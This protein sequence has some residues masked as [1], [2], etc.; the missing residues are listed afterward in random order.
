MIR[1][2]PCYALALWLPNVQ[3]GTARWFVLG[4][5]IGAVCWLLKGIEA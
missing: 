4:M 1:F 2:L 3:D 5:F